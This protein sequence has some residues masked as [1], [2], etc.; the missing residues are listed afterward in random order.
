MVWR[1]RAGGQEGRGRC[2][3][4]SGAVGEGEAESGR[5]RFMVRENKRLKSTAFCLPI[6]LHISPAPPLRLSPLPH[7]VLGEIR[8][9][10]DA[11]A[12][13]R[14]VGERA[15]ACVC[16][17]R[18]PLCTCSQKPEKRRSSV[19]SDDKRRKRQ[20]PVETPKIHNLHLPSPISHLPTFPCMRMRMRT[21]P[22]CADFDTAFFSPM[23][24]ACWVV[25]WLAGSAGEI[26][27]QGTDR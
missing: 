16:E 19:P 2:G 11:H 20:K 17:W 5:E 1:G 8:H 12:H 22:P 7:A 9:S 25:L 18:T 24:G 27:E 23:V 15:R 26:R 10:V 3:L 4:E 6:V 21:L 13:E 14:D